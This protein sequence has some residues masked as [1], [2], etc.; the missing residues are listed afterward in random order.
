MGEEGRREEK[1][2]GL[3]ADI[4]M[5]DLGIELHYRRAKRVIIW[6][7]HIHHI[8][9]SLIRCAW[10][11]FECTFEVCEIGAV[12]Y[13]AGLYVREVV[14]V[15]VCHLFCNAAGTACRHCVAL[16]ML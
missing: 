7:P 8:C 12:A 10:R 1:A 2:H 15:D 6:Y 13:G 16:A 14:V 5:P 9:P 3:T 4:G 11:T